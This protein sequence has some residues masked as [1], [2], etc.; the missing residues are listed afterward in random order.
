MLF[1]SRRRA[2]AAPVPV[3]VLPEMA[4]TVSLG[5]RSVDTVLVTFALCTIPDVSAALLG[6]RRVLKP[7]G[8]L[9][10]CEHGRS[11]EPDMLRRQQK[12]EPLWKRI[13]GGCHLTRDIPAL[14]CDAGFEILEMDAGYMAKSPSIGGYLYRG[15]AQAVV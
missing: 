8:R 9:L 4:E 6:A 12:I 13:F 15:A 2:A 1:R 10:F 7:G 11:P 14:V 3:D 5:D